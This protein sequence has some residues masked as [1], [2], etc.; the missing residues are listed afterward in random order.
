MVNDIRYHG[1]ELDHRKQRRLK[2]KI[3]ISSVAKEGKPSLIKNDDF[4]RQEQKSLQHHV[5]DLVK[6]KYTI[7]IK[8]EDIDTCYRPSKGGIVISFLNTSAGS[9]YSELAT[10]IKSATGV[11]KNVYFNFMLTKRR[12]HLLFEVRKLKQLKTI[13]KYFSDDDG[14]I[15]MIVNANSRSEKLTNIR[16]SNNSM[17]KIMT[18]DEMQKKVRELK[19]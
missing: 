14:N 16:T 13:F 5:A 3:V 7:T 11:D 15:S 9:A 19:Q 6:D 17:L 2:G 8:A 18:V 10:K 4:L 1:D 12:S